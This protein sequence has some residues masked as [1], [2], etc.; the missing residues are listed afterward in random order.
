M[1]DDFGVLFSG[2]ALDRIKVLVTTVYFPPVSLNSHHYVLTLPNT[3]CLFLFV[4]CI[5]AQYAT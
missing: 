3:T 1:D 5:E 4:S 2:L